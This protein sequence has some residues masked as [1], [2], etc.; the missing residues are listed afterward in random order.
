MTIASR[1][2]RFFHRRHSIGSESAGGFV[3]ISGC[4]CELS[5]SQ[6]FAPSLAIEGAAIDSQIPPRSRRQHAAQACFHSRQGSTLAGLNQQLP[7]NGLVFGRQ[8]PVAADEEIGH[9]GGLDDAA[10]MK[11]ATSARTGPNSC[12]GRIHRRQRRQPRAFILD[13]DQGSAAD[14]AAVQPAGLEFNV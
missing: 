14:L 3:L 5:S 13:R 7:K 12:G 10:E 6:S 1:R 2:A 9:K 4:L 11:K 8:W